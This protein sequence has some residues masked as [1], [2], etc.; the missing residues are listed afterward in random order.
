MTIAI[1]RGSKATNQTSW[2][3]KT[4]KNTIKKQEQMHGF[5]ARTIKIKQKK[6]RLWVYIASNP[7]SSTALD[8]SATESDTDYIGIT[9]YMY[10]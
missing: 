5:M 9:D 4:S 7:Y 2:T 1:Y 10:W 6:T 8:V 3:S